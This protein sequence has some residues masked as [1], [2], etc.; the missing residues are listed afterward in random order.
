M[1]RAHPVYRP[2]TLRPSPSPTL[3]RLPRDSQLFHG[4]GIKL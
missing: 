1:D 3:I 4:W 2:Q